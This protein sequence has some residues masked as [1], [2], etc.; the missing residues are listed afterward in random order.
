MITKFNQVF[1][2]KSL[3]SSI[4]STYAFL[5]SITRHNIYSIKH[6]KIKCFL[7]SRPWSIK[8]D[9]NA[10]CHMYINEFWHI[11]TD[12]IQVDI[13]TNVEKVYQIKNEIVS[14]FFDEKFEQNLKFFREKFTTT[15]T[16]L[17]HIPYHNKFGPNGLFRNFRSRMFQTSHQHQCGQLSN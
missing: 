14:G 5:M 6:L 17:D 10:I 3:V 13:S 2:L 1:R 7:S 8:K 4:I 9:F 11:R 16:F 12:T 15:L